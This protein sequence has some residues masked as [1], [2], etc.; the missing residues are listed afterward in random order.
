M[1][2]KGNQPRLFATLNP[3]TNKWEWTMM[4]LE[5][6]IEHYEELQIGNTLTKIIK[7]PWLLEDI[8]SIN[9]DFVY[10]NIFI[11]L[12]SFFYLFYYN[13]TLGGVFLGCMLIIIFL[14]Y[15]RKLL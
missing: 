3:M 11:I 7:A 14:C 10:R 1:K 4:S 2:D 5:E 13:K 12:S 8:F 9:E 6:D 15:L